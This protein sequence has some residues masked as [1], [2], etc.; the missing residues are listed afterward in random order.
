[1]NYAQLNEFFY[2]GQDNLSSRKL[3]AIKYLFLKVVNVSVGFLME[4]IDSVVRSGKFAG[5][6]SQC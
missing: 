3:I 2:G 5:S 4:Y 6:S 1:M